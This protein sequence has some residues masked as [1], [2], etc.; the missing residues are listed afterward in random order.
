MRV[1]LLTLSLLF[2][3]LSFASQDEGIFAHIQTSKG[4]IIVKLAYQQAPLTVINFVSLAEGTK[5]SN[6]ELG[7]P[8]YD[9]IS[10]HRVIADFMI[11]SGDPKGT[12]MGGPGYLFMDEFSKLKH[13]KPGILSMANSGPT[14][15]GSQFFITHI[16]TPWL[17]GKHSVFGS[18]TEGMSVVNSIEQGDTIEHVTIKRVGEN[19]SNFAT[20]ENAFNAELAAK[21]SV[22]KAALEKQIQAF[23]EMA[24]AT[25]PGAQKNDSGYFSLSTQAGAGEEAKSGNNISIEIS[26]ELID[27]TV[28]QASGNPVRFRLGNGEILGIIDSAAT[29]MA[30]GEERLAIATYQQSFGERDTGIPMNSILV[31]KL[32]RL[33]DGE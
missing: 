11:Q 2:S 27:G 32:K 7:V 4:E 22:N 8:F 14:T 21:S 16:P 28:L 10:F 31:F 29:G 33:A 19:A 25:F 12:G 13:D 26:I 6:K 30:V 18:V 15:N 23:E 24:V 20:G 5:V 9:G 1:L 17:D 3:S